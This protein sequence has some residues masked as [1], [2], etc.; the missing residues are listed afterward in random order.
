MLY[1]AHKNFMLA[2]QWRRMRWAAHVACMEKMT[3]GW[4]VTGE[5]WREDTRWEGI[6]RG[7]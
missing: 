7:I 6:I 1:T 4:G 3:D 2:S 5:V